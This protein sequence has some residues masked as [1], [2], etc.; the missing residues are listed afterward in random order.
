M[1]TATTYHPTPWTVSDTGDGKTDVLDADRRYVITDSHHLPTD[2]WLDIVRRVNT[3]DDLLAACE[4]FVK[5]VQFHA[6][7]YGPLTT[8]FEAARAAIAKAKA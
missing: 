3:H 7:N 5:T 1:T 2:A 4:A 8:P 6:M